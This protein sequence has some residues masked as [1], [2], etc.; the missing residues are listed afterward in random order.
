MG[1]DWQ[2]DAD[3]RQSVTPRSARQLQPDCSHNL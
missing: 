2:R 3:D 1:C